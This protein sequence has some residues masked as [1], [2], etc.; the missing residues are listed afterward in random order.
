MQ[1]ALCVTHKI[2]ELVQQDQGEDYVG[3]I[4]DISKMIMLIVNV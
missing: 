3:V 4:Q 2:I 1:T